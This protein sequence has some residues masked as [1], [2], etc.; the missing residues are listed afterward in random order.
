MKKL[1]LG[2]Q[3]IAQG[4]YEAGVKVATAYP[5][6]PSTEITEN[7]AKFNEIYAEWAPNEKVAL[8]VAIG[9][10]IA[11]ARSIVSMK[12]VGVNVAADPLFTYAYCGVNAGLVLVCCDDPGMHSSQNEQDSRYYAISAHVPMLE[13]SD[14][15]EAKEFT[16]LA[17]EISEKYD[18]P[19]MLRMT[20]RVSHSQSFVECLERKEIPLKEYKKDITKYAMMP[21]MARGRRVA[22]KEREEKLLKDCNDLKINFAEYKGKTGVI[23]A[24][25]TYSYVKEALSDVSVLKLGMVN[26]LPEK[27]IKEFCLKCDKIYIVEEMEPVIEN[28]VKKL[29]INC[30][31]KE[32]FPV[33]GE[34]FP[35]LIKEKITGE[36]TDKISSVEVP[37]RPPVMCAGCPHRGVFYVLSKLKLTVTG[38]IGCYTLGA[39]P[40]LSAVDTVI[41]MGASVGVNHGF[42]K[43][44]PQFSKNSVAVIGDSTFVHS[45][46]TG[47]IDAVYNK[48]KTTLIILDN[49]TTGMTGHQNHPATG[50]T[51]R[52]EQTHCL[53]LKDVCIACGAKKVDEV[54]SF[55]IEK[56]ESLIKEHL[57]YDGVSVIIAKEPCA[58]L[59]KKIKE[60]VYFVNDKCVNC[61]ACMKLGCPALQITDGKVEVNKELCTDC[62]LCGKLCKFGA[63]T[64]VDR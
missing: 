10:S 34:I 2:N 57:S 13:P 22:V 39:Q 27:L 19:V 29:G 63:L 53:N 37:Q 9:A 44:N 60:K 30:I 8:E 25:D 18:T 51:I 11:G 3:G 56:I 55:D 26:P 54:H 33:Q 62:G 46:I 12:H 31:G 41:C 49:S 23:C 35:S 7:I 38:D 17:F 14:S 1:L 16:K 52:N 15:N 5:G 20:T 42:I 43:A 40:P 4:A 21:A 24:G 48:S 47:L 45:G 50:L 58:L 28:A 61:R 32:V 64:E 6:T 59:N 36:K